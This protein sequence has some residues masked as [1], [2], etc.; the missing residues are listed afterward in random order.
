M[1]TKLQ[2]IGKP[3]KQIKTTYDNVSDWTSGELFSQLSEKLKWY[4]FTN[5]NAKVIYLQIKKE[6]NFLGI[7]FPWNH[8]FVASRLQ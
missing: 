2:N 3:K 1:T 5:R 7:F 8:V 6:Q 4:L